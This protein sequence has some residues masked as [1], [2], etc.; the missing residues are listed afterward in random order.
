MSARSRLVGAKT[1][2]NRV[3]FAYA[4]G[5]ERDKFLQQLDAGHHQL[6]ALE[7]ALFT[8]LAF[9]SGRLFVGG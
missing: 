4:G 9:T 3:R 7:R 1:P 2:W 5:H 6:R 8:A